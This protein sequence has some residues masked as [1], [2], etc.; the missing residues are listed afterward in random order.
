MEL[1]FS[2]ATPSQTLGTFVAIGWTYPNY[3]GVGLGLIYSSPKTNTIVSKAC[4]S[5]A[6]GSTN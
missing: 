5:D 6:L 2:N 4:T 3:F 1:T